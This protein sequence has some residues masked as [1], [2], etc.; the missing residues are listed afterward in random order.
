MN[1]KLFKKKRIVKSAVIMVILNK[2]N[3]KHID[4]F[5]NCDTMYITILIYKEERTVVGGVS[6]DDRCKR[7]AQR[8]GR[9]LS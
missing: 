9:P 6:A 4:F 8:C 2:N 1:E 3:P 5:I 7:F